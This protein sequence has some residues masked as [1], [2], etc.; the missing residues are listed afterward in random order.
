MPTKHRTTLVSY[1]PSAIRSKY[2]ASR[3][4]SRLCWLKTNITMCAPLGEELRFS[5]CNGFLQT[6]L[7]KLDCRPYMIERCFNVQ[8]FMRRL[9]QHRSTPRISQV[10]HS[11]RVVQR[12]GRPCL[13]KGS[14]P[15]S[16][17]VPAHLRLPKGH[18]RQMGA[19]VVMFF[20]MFSKS[21]PMV[22]RC[23]P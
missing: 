22:S 3:R 19:G 15:R 17:T 11:L 23:S 7:C 5:L 16:E 4:L 13:V 20:A 14:G 6:A 1:F 9:K 10:F 18:S 8:K 12:H 21:K 2:S